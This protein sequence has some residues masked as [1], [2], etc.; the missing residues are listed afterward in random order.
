MMDGGMQTFE[1]N[2]AESVAIARKAIESGRPVMI[3]YLIDGRLRIARGLVHKVTIVDAA[4]DPTWRVTMT[5]AAGAL[6]SSDSVS[7]HFSEAS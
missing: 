4:D 3:G 7:V 5:A 2:N 6:P 1:T